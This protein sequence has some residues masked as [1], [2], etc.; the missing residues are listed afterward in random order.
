MQ[1]SKLAELANAIGGETLAEYQ[2]LTADSEYLER[3]VA[4]FALV[5]RMSH[6]Q[7]R[8]EWEQLSPKEQI[9]CLIEALELKGGK[10]G[11]YP[12]GQWEALL[13]SW[14]GYYDR[15]LGRSMRVS[16]SKTSGKFVSGFERRI[17]KAF[18]QEAVSYLERYRK[19][20]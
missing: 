12:D 2:K 3:I 11:D 17:E 6:N 19:L 1:G 16:I 8:R 20:K 5:P 15:A 4:A 18:G 9:Q 7:S 14:F 13:T 10:D